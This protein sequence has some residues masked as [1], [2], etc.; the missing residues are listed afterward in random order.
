MCQVVTNCEA[1]PFTDATRAAQ[2]SNK[3]PRCCDE[4]QSVG[5][6]AAVGSP[7]SV[8]AAHYNLRI[9]RVRTPPAAAAAPVLSHASPCPTAAKIKSRPRAAVVPPPHATASVSVSRDLNA[10]V[11]VLQCKMA[12]MQEQVNGAADGIRQ[13]RQL[14][15]VLVMQRHRA[16]MAVRAASAVQC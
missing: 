5:P 8:E 1:N 10:E 2:S 13:L 7:T 6:A 4:K 14:V 11:K 12:Q 15:G 16:A 9:K 3:R